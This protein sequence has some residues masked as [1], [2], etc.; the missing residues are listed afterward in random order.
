MSESS[1]ND[2]LMA[3]GELKGT[4]AAFTVGM[5][6][7]KEERAEVRK[8]LND[9]RDSLAIQKE[10]HQQ[11]GARLIKVETSAGVHEKAVAK[12]QNWMLG[13]G[14]AVTLIFGIVWTVL[15]ATI[16]GTLGLK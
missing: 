11:M 1:H 12:Q 15:G 6:E 5:A 10:Q 13:F 2:I 9:I 14:A 16:K 3:I 7:A 4:M 8:S